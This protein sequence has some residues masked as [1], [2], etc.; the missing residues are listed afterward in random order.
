MKLFFLLIG[1]S[2]DTESPQVELSSHVCLFQRK[3]TPSYT[4]E[5]D[6]VEA[7]KIYWGLTFCRL[8][9]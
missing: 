3:L 2:I 6:Y 4:V 8:L 1:L 5:D 9:P 7:S